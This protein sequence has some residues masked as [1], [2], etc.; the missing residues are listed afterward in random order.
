MTISREM[1]ECA[2]GYEN[3]GP[4]VCFRTMRPSREVLELIVDVAPSTTCRRLW[5]DESLPDRAESHVDYGSEKPLPH[6]HSRS[7]ALQHHSVTLSK[8]AYEDGRWNDMQQ[9]P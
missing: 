6:T 2:N 5:P 7:N 8:S 1:Q 4:A 3:A 9:L